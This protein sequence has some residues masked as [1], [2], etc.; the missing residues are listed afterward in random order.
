MLPLVSS[1]TS[2]QWVGSRW[3][4]EGELHHVGQHWHRDVHADRRDRG[5]DHGQPH[6]H[7]HLHLWRESDLHG[8]RG[9][10]VR[11]VG[12][13]L[14]R[15]SDDDWLRRHVAG[16]VICGGGREYVSG[17]HPHVV[18]HHPLLH[19]R[20]VAPPQTIP[21]N[22]PVLRLK[23]LN[24]AN[25]F[26]VWCFSPWRLDS[27]GNKSKTG[28]LPCRGRLAWAAGQVTRRSWRGGLS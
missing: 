25:Q 6:H 28:W 13:L 3:W 21:K 10:A 27:W 23:R 19:F 17:W 11:I 26:Q 16:Q 14:L 9:L 24:A 5:A 7:V 4:Q 22:L 15:D 2:R 12:L 20:S 1:T 8:G 18:L